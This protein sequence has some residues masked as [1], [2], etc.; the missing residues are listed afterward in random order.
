MGG[1]TFWWPPQLILTISPNYTLCTR[2]QDLAGPMN[3]GLRTGLKPVWQ[4]KT[5]AD[6]ATFQFIFLHYCIFFLKQSELDRNV[7]VGKSSNICTVYIK[8]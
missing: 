7:H 1:N 8:F 3:K 4:T 6:L 5:P 2:L